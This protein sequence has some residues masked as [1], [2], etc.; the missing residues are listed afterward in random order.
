MNGS[1]GL[2]S[3]EDLV[4][5]VK[6]DPK[7]PHATYKCTMCDCYFNDEYARKGH[8]KG[9][10]HRLNYKKMYQPDLYVEP[11]KQQKK[12]MEKRKRMYELRRGGGRMRGGGVN[13]RVNGRGGGE[14]EQGNSQQQQQ[15]Q[16]QVDLN[17]LRRQE[18]AALA[19]F[20]SQK[21]VS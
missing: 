20:H 3:G 14:G 12:E 6:N 18:A 21:N 8:V 9:R 19:Q 13:G 17:E 15:Q 16:Q 7:F 5:P 11:T 4:V 10:R 2:F 1:P